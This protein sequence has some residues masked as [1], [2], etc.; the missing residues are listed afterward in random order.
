MRYNQHF[1]TRKTA[2]T[3]PVPGREQVK[4][5]AGGY[6]FAVDPWTKL[7]R[8]LILGSEGGTYYATE[9]NLTID[10]A[11]SVAECIKLD[12]AR[13]VKRIVE[14]SDSGRAP[15]NDPAIF[16]LAMAS[17]V[18]D[19]ATRRLAREALSKVCRTGT[20]LF[21]FA[22]NIGAFG[23]WGR[24]TR[25]AI[26]SWYNNMPLDRLLLQLVKYQQRNG[27]SHRDL[28]RLAHPRTSDAKRN[29]AYSW[30]V[31]GDQGGQEKKDPKSIQM[32]EGTIIHGFDWA[33]VETD[34]KQLCK[35]IR[36]F[37]LPHECVPT[38]FK[39]DP[40]VQ[41]AL[42]ENMPMT[43]MIRNLGNMSKSG[44][45]APLSDATGE[46]IR[47][48]ADA[49]AL[50]KARIHP[51]AVLSALMTYQQG[52]GM[53]GKGTWTVVGSIVDALN[54]AFYDAFKHV[55]PTGKR[56]FIGL[57][58][59]G[60][61]SGG[62]I[63]GVPGLT[64]AVAAACMA[65]TIARTEKNY[66]IMGFQDRITRLDISP[67]MRLDEV[68]KKTANLTFGGTDCALPMVYAKEQKMNVDAFMVLTDN[69]TWAGGIQPFQALAEYRRFSG[70][71][72]KEVVVG[73]T[74][75]DFSIAD[76][77]DGGMMDVVGFDTAAPQLISDFIR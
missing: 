18:G 5:S 63:A 33:K 37:K 59:S 28:L 15:K 29:A 67:R 64:P 57:D 16:A 30:V 77:Q 23:G 66:V 19:D 9:R 58:V 4:N 52:H 62:V 35:L 32:L 42:L 17:K 27:W 25:N 14:I 70:I 72:A 49:E 51:I 60:S 48:L 50:Q 10:N 40:K 71:N 76:P 68:I 55:R 54:E 69:E 45:L 31:N 3:E 6:V 47:R 8:F 24:G 75:T 44:L 12:G 7:D 46:V 13:A 65:M 26:A 11:K 38:Q 2:Q 74:A 61:M 20:H 22:D 21:T 53:R 1:N 56:I 39:D 34:A 43:A 41:E 36:E 73:M